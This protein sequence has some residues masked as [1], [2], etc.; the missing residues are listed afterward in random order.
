MAPPVEM[1]LFDLGGV[2]VELQGVSEMRELTSLATDEELWREWLACPWVRAFESGTCSP[3][4]FA[5]GVVDT[6]RLP[7]SAG[8][9]L[10][11]F[12]AWPTGPLMGAEEL[13]AEVAGLMPVGCFSNTN[14]LHWDGCFSRWPLVGL[15]ERRFLSFEL[16]LLKPDVAAFEKVA[17]MVRPPPG[18][19]LFLDDNQLNVDGAREAGFQAERVRGPEEARSALVAAGVLPAR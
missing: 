12:E 8:D 14:S 1:V 2:L 3:E 4:E 6:W 5:R 17:S 13:V 16:G 10:K 15:F 9:Y 18:R 11:R 7:I 19:V